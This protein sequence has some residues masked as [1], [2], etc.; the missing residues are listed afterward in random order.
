MLKC[1]RVQ[2]RGLVKRRE[3]RGGQAMGLWSVKMHTVLVETVG[4]WIAD[5]IIDRCSLQ[6]ELNEGSIEA[7]QPRY[8]SMPALTNSPSWTNTRL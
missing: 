8:C 6:K 3:V 1:G 2:L 5:C 4:L 7:Y